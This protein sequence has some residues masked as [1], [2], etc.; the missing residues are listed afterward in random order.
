MKGSVLLVLEKHRLLL[1]PKRLW[2]ACGRRDCGGA[3]VMRPHFR[4]G[5]LL[6]FTSKRWRL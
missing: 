3:F 6:Q 1:R 2:R 4:E 5:R